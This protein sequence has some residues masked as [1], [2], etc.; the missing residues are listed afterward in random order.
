MTEAFVKGLGIPALRGRDFSPYF[1][2]NT[3]ENA[4]YH[5]RNLGNT[6]LFN[7][8]C[9]HMMNV[10]GSSRT[11]IE[12][13]NLEDIQ[14]YQM[15]SQAY[16]LSGYGKDIDVSGL[17]YAP[18]KSFGVRYLALDGEV[19]GGRHI[20]MGDRKASLLDLGP[21]TAADLSVKSAKYNEIF[22]VNQVLAARRA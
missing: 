5:C 12:F 20:A 3:F 21:V 22:D 8:R 2:D 16:N 4:F 18:L 6:E 14:L 19:E 11:F 17:S 7:R 10:R 13:H 9:G 1:F 15:Y